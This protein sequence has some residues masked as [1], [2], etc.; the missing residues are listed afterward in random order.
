[1]VHIELIIESH[2]GSN[3]SDDLLRCGDRKTLRS[4]RSGPDRGSTDR[5]ERSAAPSRWAVTAARRT[6]VNMSALLH[7]SMSAGCQS[8]L[9]GPGHLP[10]PRT[11]S[12][13]L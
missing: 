13:G 2:F 7:C 10:A 4:R 11:A 6:G 12:S 5:F 1:M 3:E 9:L 8:N